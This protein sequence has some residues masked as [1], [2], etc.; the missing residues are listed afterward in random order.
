[1]KLKTLKDLEKDLEWKY[2]TI[3]ALKKEAI[4]WVKEDKEVLGRLH[5]KDKGTWTISLY[6]W[7]ERL[8]ITEEDLK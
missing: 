2:D 1:M 5:P 3:T 8:D 7:M 4:K 6:R